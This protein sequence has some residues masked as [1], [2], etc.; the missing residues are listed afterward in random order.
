MRSASLSNDISTTGRYIARHGTD[1]DYYDQHNY[2][3]GYPGAVGR[4]LVAVTATRF[5][6][7][8][9]PPEIGK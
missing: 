9:C 1:A 5:R 4:G 6:V 3:L 2:H 8:R 7:A